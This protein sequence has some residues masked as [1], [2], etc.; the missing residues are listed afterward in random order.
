MCTFV[1]FRFQ[2]MR[3]K[4]FYVSSNWASHILRKGPF[5]SLNL[6]EWW[7]VGVFGDSREVEWRLLALHT[8]TAG[9]HVHGEVEA[10]TRNVKATVSTGR[11]AISV[12]PNQF[13][14]SIVRTNVIWQI[15][16]PGTSTWSCVNLS[17]VFIKLASKVLHKTH[18]SEFPK[19]SWRTDYV[20]V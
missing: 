15:H 2:M 7:V 14:E 16:V 3:S 8:A 19:D 10:V 9:H 5:V 17:V 12:A 18:M 11:A 6:H 20:Q 13:V 1:R 4:Y